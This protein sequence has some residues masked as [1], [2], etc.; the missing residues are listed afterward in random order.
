MKTF[1]PLALTLML[2]GPA[3]AGESIGLRAGFEPLAFLA[4]WCWRGEF[5]GGQVDT[6][7]FEPMYGGQHLRDRHE[8][9][10][11]PEPYAGETVWSVTDGR[12]GYVYFNS[13]GGVST[14]A[15]TPS[16][17][18]GIAFPDEAYT[19][20]DGGQVVVSTYWENISDTGY[21]SLVVER[22][23]DGSTRERRVRYERIAMPSN[24]KNAE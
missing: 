3:P 20:P 15:A 10:G 7:C 23:P 9:T 1:A 22:F 21:D 8:V 19:G 11:G 12:I 5:P 6:H 18:G 14:G 24:S 2:A 17:D 4:G 16:A 13:L